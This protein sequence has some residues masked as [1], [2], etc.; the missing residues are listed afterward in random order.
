MPAGLFCIFTPANMQK[1]PAHSYVSNAYITATNVTF[2]YRK[3]TNQTN[4]EKSD[5]STHTLLFKLFYK[6]EDPIKSSPVFMEF[7]I[8]GALFK[9]TL[10]HMNMTKSQAPLDHF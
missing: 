4:N 1:S 5:K 10:P 6:I 8:D 3:V 2:Y 9:R 7:F